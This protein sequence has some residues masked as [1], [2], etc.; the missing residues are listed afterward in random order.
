[1]PTGSEILNARHALG[2]TQTAAAALLDVDRVTWARYESEA[3]R[4]SMVEWRY[5]L[6]V[7]GVQRIPFRARR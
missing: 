6:H 2:L 7:A 4:I 3:R 1:M 5:W